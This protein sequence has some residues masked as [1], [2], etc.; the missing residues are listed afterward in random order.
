LLKIRDYVYI[1]SNEQIKELQGF[2]RLLNLMEKLRTGTPC[3]SIIAD[4]NMHHVIK[5][6]SL[7]RFEYTMA[8]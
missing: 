5:A 7:T 1:Y 6:Y 2:K 8:L 4:A 3:T